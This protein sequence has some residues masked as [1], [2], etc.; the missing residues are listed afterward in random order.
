MTNLEMR[1]V[2]TG[3]S[4]AGFALL[5]VLAAGC[6]RYQPPAERV[7][8]SNVNAL[9]SSLASSAA[10]TSPAAAGPIA[11]PTGWAT[12]KGS[13]KIAGT[14]PARQPVNVDKDHGVCAPRGKQV[15]SEALVVDS[16]GGIK[17]VVIYLVLPGR[18]EFPVGD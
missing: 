11:D 5:A 15:L 18:R 17:D 1:V 3:T 13:F 16:A 12:I 2:I 14:P 10:E 4:G 7:V 8:V 9:R 6:A